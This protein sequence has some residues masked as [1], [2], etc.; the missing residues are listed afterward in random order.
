MKN[1]HGAYA[2]S[3]ETTSRKRG[4]KM[5]KTMKK[6]AAWLI[7]AVMAV[8][9]WAAAPQAT[10]EDADGTID[11]QLQELVKEKDR[12]TV[13]ITL[14]KL[15][16]PDGTSETGWRAVDAFSTVKNVTPQTAEEATE[17]MAQVADIILLKKAVLKAEGTEKTNRNGEATFRGL[18]AGIYYG[19]MTGGPDNLTVAP[20]LVAVSAANRM[21]ASV[22]LKSTYRPQPPENPE[23]EKPEE[24]PYTLTIYYIYWDGREAHPTYKEVLWPDEV[25]YVISP[26]I[27]GYRCTLPLVEGV[28][29]HRDMYY[30]VIYIPTGGRTLIDLDEY[31][32]PLGL[33]EIQIHVGVCYE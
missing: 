22:I 10:A 12:N 28:M 29:P 1:D 25:Y 2:A 9:L 13:R 16:E 7:L 31:N 23:E 26:D 19:Y 30:T 18:T 21:R 32:S 11:V 27:K 17:T 33:G 24:H 5:Q 14:Y 3:D 4:K 6:A 20:F 15:A 8:S